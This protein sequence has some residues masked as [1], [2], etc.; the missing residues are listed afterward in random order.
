MNYQ[1]FIKLRKKGKISAGIENSTAL[2]LVEYLPKRYRAAVFFW[3][4]V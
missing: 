4:W 3:S 2:K 1:E